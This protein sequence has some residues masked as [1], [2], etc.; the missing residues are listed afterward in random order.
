MSRVA[1]MLDVPGY[2]EALLRENLLRTA[3]FVMPVE[4]IHGFVVQ[5]MTLRQHAELK[6]ARS[7]YLAPTRTPTPAETVQFL[8]RLAPQFT[9]EQGRAWRAFKKK[10]KN[11]FPPAP[12]FWRA[13]DNNHQRDFAAILQHAQ[14]VTAIREYMTEVMFDR[15]PASSANSAPDYFSDECAVCARLARAYGWRESDIMDLPLKRIFQY[16]KECR[17]ND[18]HAVGMQAVMHN[19]SD[20]VLGDFMAGKRN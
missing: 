16:L 4:R 19:P 5:P 7:P 6:L 9:R 17:E 11:I 3:A 10:L 15:P 13:A 12:R 20:K 1:T 8:W 2:A 14:L 18:Y